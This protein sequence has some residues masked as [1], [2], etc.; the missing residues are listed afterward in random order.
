MKKP[1][2]EN[3]LKGQEGSIRFD[4]LDDGEPFRFNGNTKWYN[5]V[6]WNKYADNDGNV[7]VLGHVREKVIIIY[8]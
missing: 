3:P 2:W 7:K 5:K 1:T 4:F 6:D 8:K